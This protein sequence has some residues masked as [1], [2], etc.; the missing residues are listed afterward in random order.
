MLSGTTYGLW[1]ANLQAFPPQVLFCL[2]HSSPTPDS[3]SA[4]VNGVRSASVGIGL[5]DDDD[6]DSQP[7]KASVFN[8]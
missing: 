6:E 3:I 4:Y 5:T 2:L 8:S 1:E 7:K